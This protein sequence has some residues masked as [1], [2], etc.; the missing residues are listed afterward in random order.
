MQRKKTIRPT[1]RR[2]P[3]SSSSSDREMGVKSRPGMA[4]VPPKPMYRREATQGKKLLPS[5]I[6]FASS[7]ASTAAASTN[8]PYQRPS[9]GKKSGGVVTV[10]KTT[11][12][13]SQPRRL[14]RQFTIQQSKQRAL[15]IN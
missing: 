11:V 12:K 7:T 3:S 9:K 14:T 2:A 4:A 6:S 10:G 13:A 15:G 1:L 5:Q 8:T